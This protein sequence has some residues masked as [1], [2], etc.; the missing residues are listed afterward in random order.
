[1]RTFLGL[2]G[3][4]R[5]FVPNF[6]TLAVPL[7]NLTKKEGKRHIEWTEEAEA[8]F[9]K[10]K[11]ALC[12]EPVLATVDFDLPFVLQTD[13][14]D[15]GLGAVLS[16]VRDQIEQP[17]T[18]ISRK[19]LQQEQNYS[20]VEK[21]CLA[22]GKLRYYLTSRPFSLV[23]DHAPLKWMARNKDTNARITR[24]FLELQDYQFKVEH[25]AGK[26]HGNADARAEAL[27]SGP[28]GEGMDLRGR[29]CGTPS[30]PRGPTVAS[31]RR[32][33]GGRVIHGVYLPRCALGGQ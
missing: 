24:W 33:Q 7:F 23:T 27:W 9:Q 26:K 11:D 22:I 12:Q 1:M 2:L 21:E 29:V 6:A 3:Y 30:F 4:Y 25:R 28:C 13:A 16:Q 10:L 14:S 31:H 20:T 17:I 15:V 5:Q 18:Y 8:S 19:L 32:K